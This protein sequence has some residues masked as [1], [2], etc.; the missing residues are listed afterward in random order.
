METTSQPKLTLSSTW[1]V[2]GS[3]LEMEVKDQVDFGTVLKD[4]AV[5][6][7]LVHITIT[8]IIKITIITIMYT[9]WIPNCTIP[10]HFLS[11]KQFQ[12]HQRNLPWVSEED[13]HDE[14]PVQAEG[15]HRDVPQG[16]RCL[17]P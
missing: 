17:R 15:E 3:K 10:S 8:I 9:H 11:Q 7:Q 16:L 4:G 2:I 1:Q 6:C 12:T 14:G 13:Q 5:L